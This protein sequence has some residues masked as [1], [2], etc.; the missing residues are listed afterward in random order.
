MGDDPLLPIVSDSQP[1][2]VSRE[3]C[4]STRSA[5]AYFTQADETAWHPF[6][7]DAAEAESIDVPIKRKAEDNSDDEE[8][9]GGE[10][11]PGQ[12]ALN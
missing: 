9:K 1:S 10:S 11:A 6:T 8:E 2:P 12:C 7:L 5:R 4:M 3:P